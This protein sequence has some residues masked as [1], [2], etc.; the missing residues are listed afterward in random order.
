M[1]SRV[2]SDRFKRKPDAQHLPM[3][4]TAQQPQTGYTTHSNF[5]S[6]L[7]QSPLSN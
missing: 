3:L 2:F 5:A 7:K 6:T 1:L 4:H